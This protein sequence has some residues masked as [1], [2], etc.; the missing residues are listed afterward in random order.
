MIS[1]LID[2]YKYL[3]DHT[4]MPSIPEV[5]EDSKSSEE[6]SVKLQWN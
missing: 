1:R 4:D 5:K 2:C 3:I 6:N